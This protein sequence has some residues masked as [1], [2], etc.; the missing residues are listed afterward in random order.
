[1]WKQDKKDHLAASN[2]KGK[3]LGRVFLPDLSHE[4]SYRWEVVFCVRRLEDM[5]YPYLGQ[6]QKLE[7]IHNTP[8]SKLWGTNELT[9]YR[10][11][12]ESIFC[13]QT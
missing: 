12:M 8:D 4:A 9:A 10:I 2:E 5:R 11:Y 13:L 3:L 7:L 1:M 6:A